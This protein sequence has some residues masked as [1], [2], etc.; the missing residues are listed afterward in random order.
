MSHIDTKRPHQILE[1]LKHEVKLE[2]ELLSQ[3]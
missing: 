2:I 1:K 3:A